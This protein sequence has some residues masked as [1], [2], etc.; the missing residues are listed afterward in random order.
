MKHCCGGLYTNTV[1][2]LLATTSFKF[3]CPF[4][5]KLEERAQRLFATKGKP[6]GALDSSL[7]AKS[8][9]SSQEALVHKEIANLEAFVYKYS[10]L[11]GVSHRNSRLIELVVVEAWR[12][13]VG[14][15]EQPRV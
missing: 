7:F 8:K 6:L 3:H 1:Y 2:G 10:E 5:S 15:L 14:G 11:V 12:H 13:G 4:C 9:S